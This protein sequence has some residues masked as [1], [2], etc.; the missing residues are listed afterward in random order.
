MKTK[1]N[2]GKKLTLKKL[3]ISKITNTNT[4]RGGGGGSL[5]GW[6]GC[7]TGRDGNP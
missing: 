4:I 2:K 1:A 5:G 6:T 7:N 3:E